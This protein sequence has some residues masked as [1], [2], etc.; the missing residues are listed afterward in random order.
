MSSTVPLNG[1]TFYIPAS[2]VSKGGSTFGAQGNGGTHDC[3]EYLAAPNPCVGSG[4]FQ[5]PSRS[6]GTKFDGA[7][8]WVKAIDDG[9]S[10]TQSSSAQYVYSTTSNN[11]LGIGKQGD[12]G[13]TKSPAPGPTSDIYP[14]VDWSLL[15]ENQTCQYD[16]TLYAWPY[17]MSKPGHL[18]MLFDNQDSS[19]ASFT[20]ASQQNFTGLIYNPNGEI[21]VSGAGKGSGGTPWIGGQIVAKDI[22]LGGTSAVDVQYRPCGS[23]STVCG[24]GIGT[25]LVQ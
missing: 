21:D 3:C 23:G 19:T 15:A 5:A 17:E 6:D 4:S 10:G 16:Q 20:G 18:H 24:S 9:V 1:V 22:T 11:G 2:S 7:A 25:E 8:T 14:N 13:T 12:F